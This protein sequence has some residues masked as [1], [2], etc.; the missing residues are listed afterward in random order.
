M[1]SLK[2]YQACAGTSALNWKMLHNTDTNQSH[3]GLI[4]KKVSVKNPL[5]CNHF[6]C[7]NKGNTRQTFRVCTLFLGPK[8][9]FEPFPKVKLPKPAVWPSIVPTSFPEKVIFALGNHHQGSMNITF[10]FGG[11]LG[12]GFKAFLG[13]GNFF[14]QSGLDIIVDVWNGGFE[15]GI[16]LYGKY[17]TG[18]WLAISPH[19]KMFHQ[20]RMIFR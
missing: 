13:P 5:V 7:N 20:S 4:K 1:K 8:S 14:F 6:P 17:Q 12:A 18:V 2:N 3:I 9:L 11:G 15:S 19:P 10:F 16:K